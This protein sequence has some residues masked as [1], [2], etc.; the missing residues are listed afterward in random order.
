MDP[1]SGALTARSHRAL[2]AHHT[3]VERQTQDET[4]D[5]GRS[6]DPEVDVPEVEQELF[7]Q[8]LETGT[9]P[10]RTLADLRREICSAR[11]AAVDAAAAAGAAAVAVA[12]PVQLD[13]QADVTRRPVTRRWSTGSVTSPGRR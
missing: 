13:E 5:A 1:G 12:V 4:R 10:C 6:G 9:V 11:R 3:N 2:L 7:L 8:Q